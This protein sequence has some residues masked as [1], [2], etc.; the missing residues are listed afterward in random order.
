M[1]SLHVRSLC[2]PAFVVTHFPLPHDV[3]G[4]HVRSRA[5]FAASASYSVLL[6]TVCDA[7]TRSLLVLGA[8]VSYCVLLHTVTDRQPCAPL[9]SCQPE[10]PSQ[11]SQ[12]LFPRAEAKRPGAQLAHTKPSPAAL[13]CPL[14]HE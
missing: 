12:V 10:T 1:W 14:G 9:P 4:V 6:H 5:S 11:A 8:C 7:Q 13:N 2:V 3:C